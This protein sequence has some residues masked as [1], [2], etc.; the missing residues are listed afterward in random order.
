[1]I[2][3]DVAVGIYL[4]Y[5]WGWVFLFVV[6]VTESVVL[7]WFLD[8]LWYNRRIYLIVFY[9]NIITTIIGYLLFN[10][11]DPFSKTHNL[12]ILISGI[13]IYVHWWDV[14][15]TNIIKVLSFTFLITI[16][17]ES[18]FNMFFLRKFRF[19]ER[20]FYGTLLAN[21]ITYVFISFVMFSYIGFKIDNDNRHKIREFYNS[22]ME[23][24][25][26][27]DTLYDLNFYTKAN[28]SSIDTIVLEVYKNGLDFKDFIKTR[29]LKIIKESLSDGWNFS[30]DQKLNITCD[31]VISLKFDT[32]IRQLY[33]LS[34][35]N[36]SHQIIGNRFLG[37]ID[38]YVINNTLINEQIIKLENPY[39]EYEN[40]D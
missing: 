37:F 19:Y 32:N 31:Y 2:L 12:G 13:P 25:A 26:S 9:S 33:R 24:S 1:M 5:L 30:L 29:N 40:P 22:C 15:E 35:I 6:I 7:S 39:F 11:N 3:F 14:D 34:G 18:I 38:H 8:R 4:P 36:I 17:V 16:V 23:K 20:V 21:F 10:Q 27:Y 28:L